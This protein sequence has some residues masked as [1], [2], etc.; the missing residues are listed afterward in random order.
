MRGVS[1]SIMT[2]SPLSSTSV[3]ASLN[4]ALVVRY[5]CDV[6]SS[7]DAPPSN[8]PNSSCARTPA[9]TS[10]LTHSCDCAST[11]NSPAHLPFL[12]SAFQGA[13][14]SSNKETT[15]ALPVLA[16][17]MS[18]L[19]PV[20]S[21]CADAGAPWSK[22]SR[23]RATS[24]AVQAASRAVTDAAV[25]SSAAILQLCTALCSLSTRDAYRC[26]RS[27]QAEW[28]APMCV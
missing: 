16:A 4:D 22:R 28:R 15:S 12:S 20:D 23:T 19:S 14:R 2:A 21:S 5:S 1:H 27:A 13:P 11:A 7:V 25:E 24:P 9:F 26:R 6:R 8:M 18:A 3:S 10:K 17:R